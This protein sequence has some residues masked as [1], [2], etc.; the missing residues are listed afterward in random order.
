MGQIGGGLGRNS[1]CVSLYYQ[2]VIARHRVVGGDMYQNCVFRLLG[3][4]LNP[5]GSG[6]GRR[7]QQTSVARKA[8]LSRNIYSKEKRLRFVDGDGGSFAAA[9][10]ASYQG[11]GGQNLRSLQLCYLGGLVRKDHGVLIEV[12]TS[13][14]LALL[15]SVT[16][17]QQYLRVTSVHRKLLRY[18]DRKADY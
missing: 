17:S 6:T 4:N 15:L 3:R 1:I 14:V 11:E 13:C 2:C 16:P 18:S 8:V 12:T 5:K 10:V 7:I 9:A